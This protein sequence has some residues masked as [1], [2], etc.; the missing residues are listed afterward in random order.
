ADGRARSRADAVS[1]SLATVPHGSAR[2]MWAGGP[3]KTAPWSPSPLA[4]ASHLDADY[5]DRPRPRRSFRAYDAYLLRNAGGGLSPGTLQQPSTR[6]RLLERVGNCEP[7]AEL[8]HRHPGFLRYSLDRFLFL[9]HSSPPAT[10]SRT[11]AA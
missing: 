3:R 1:N 8:L 11:A 7:H 9:F 5:G 2:W 10:G 4:M 6:H